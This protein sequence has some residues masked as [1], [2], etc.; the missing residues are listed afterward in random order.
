M[1]LEEHIYTKT[2]Q[3]YGMN[4]SAFMDL[5]TVSNLATNDA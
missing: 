2:C 3:R 4:I 5:M 1:H